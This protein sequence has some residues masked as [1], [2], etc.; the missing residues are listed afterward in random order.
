[1]SK[2]THRRKVYIG[3]WFQK[4]ENIVAWQQMTG[5]VAGARN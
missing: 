3:L 4:N 2:A 5:M 1:M